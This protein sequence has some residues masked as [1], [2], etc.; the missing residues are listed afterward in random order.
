MKPAAI[1][2]GSTTAGWKTCS[3]M[4]KRLKTM[5]IQT[6]RLNHPAAVLVVGAVS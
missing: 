2:S 5:P 1:G 6:T 3:A 4:K